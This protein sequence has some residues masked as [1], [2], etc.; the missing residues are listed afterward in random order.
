MMRRTARLE[1]EVA[2]LRARAEKTDAEIDAIFYTMRRA[3]DA[4]GIPRITPP[5]PR[6]SLTVL[7]G[8]AS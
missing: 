6:P 5:R 8:G 1:A 3:C 7:P 4:A 2:E